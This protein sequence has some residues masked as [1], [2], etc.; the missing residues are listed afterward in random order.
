MVTKK[1]LIIVVLATFCLTATIFTVIPTRSQN[2]R[3]DPWLD[4]N[5]DGTINILDFAAEAVAYQSSGDPTKNVNVT[6]L[7]NYD[8]QRGNVT[9]TSMGYAPPYVVCGGYSRLSLLCLPTGV[10]IGD[11]NEIT[12]YLKK[13]VW[14]DA[15]L[16]IPPGPGSY[17]SERLNA[18]AFNMTIRQGQYWSWGSDWGMGKYITETKGPYCVL[19]FD[20]ILVGNLPENWWVTFDY[21]VYLRSE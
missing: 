13:I 3:Y 9:F 1:D 2:D 7:Y 10:Y 21:C 18:N 14:L 4:V 19:S 20:A 15:P 6:N 12:I 8:L 16:G 5:D 11:N 17:S